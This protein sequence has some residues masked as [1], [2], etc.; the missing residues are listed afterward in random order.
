MQRFCFSKK[1]FVTACSIV[2]AFPFSVRGY[3]FDRFTRDIFRHELSGNTINLHYTL[4]D[5]GS[6]GIQE[7]TPSFGT[8]DREAVQTR[9]DYLE[10]CQKKLSGYLKWGLNEEDHFTAEILDWWLTGQIKAEEYYYYQE[11]L[12]PALGIQAQLPVLLAEYPFREE[13]DIRTYLDLLSALPDYFESIASFEAEKSKQGLFMTDEA[14][15]QV[16][17]QCR[18]LIPADTIDQNHFLAATFQERLEACSFLDS[19]Q[20]IAL[21]AENLRNLN[22]YVAPSYENLCLSL[23][24]LRGTGTNPYGL[25]HVPDG[26]HYYEYLLRYSIGTNLDM[27]S[28]RQLLE[29]QIETEY[30]TIL[31]GLHQDAHLIRLAD[32]A[33]PSQESPKEILTDLQSKIQ[34][35]FPE[36][37]DISWTVKEVPDALASFLSPAFY[38]T[39][40]IDASQ[41]NVIYIN[42]ARQPD[43]TE[44][45]TTL[46][47]EGYPGHLYQNAFENGKD[48]AP[49]RNLFYV[50]GYTEGWGLYSEYYAYDFLELP[51]LQR[52]FLKAMSSLNFAICASLDLAVHGEGWTEEDCQNYLT[53]FGIRD[54]QQVHE[55]YLNILEEPSNYLKY[56]LGYLEIC[57]LK[58]SAFTRSSDLSLLDFHT[59]FL[60]AGPAPFYLL[61]QQLDSELLEVSSKLSQS[62]GQD[63]HLFSLESVHDGLHHLF[64]KN[65]MLLIGPDPFLSQRKQDD[66][67]VL[68]ASNPGYITFF[69]QIIDGS[70]QSSH[71]NRHSFRY[72]GHIFRVADADGI[73]DVHIVDGDLFKST[74]DQHTV[75]HIQHFVEQ[76]D[77]KVVKK[78]FPVQNPSPPYRFIC[79][80]V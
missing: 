62:P 50:G 27:A 8:F 30:E 10:K 9:Q 39:P 31:Y 63:F 28:I 61:E 43:Q 29:E 40:A 38:M 14:L 3:S 34:E 5:P 68:G 36:T 41:Q 37:S 19:D 67:L 56:Y 11:P 49:I 64:V 4:A 7:D 58:E 72:R 55:L 75:L 26:V 17:E 76:H 18:S 54:E 20:K 45:V 32:Q 1:I 60:E 80:T 47:H 12:G 66:P 2:L 24:K 59:W 25:F 13:S 16:L 74:G 22:R 33:P 23:E 46:A 15:D 51:E 44:L 73:N 71:R 65:R 77:Q 78:L 57:R 48:Y 79:A 6:Y 52:T 70:S 53:S 21:E 35:D 42:P 69:H